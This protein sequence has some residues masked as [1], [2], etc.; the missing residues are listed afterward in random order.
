MPAI[1]HLSTQIIKRS[2]GRSSVACAAY[3]SGEALHDELEGTTFKFQREDRVVSSE[4]IAPAYATEDWATD[5]AKLWNSVEAVEKRCNAQ[6]AKE[7]EVA[8][9]NDLT[10][11]RQQELLAGW[12]DENFTQKGFIADV[13]IHRSPFGADFDNDHAHVMSTLREVDPETGGWKKLKTQSFKT[14][15]IDLEELRASWAKHVNAALQK[16]GL[17][18]QEVDHRSHKRRGITDVQPGIHVGYAGKGIE[19]RGGRSWRAEINREIH[20]QNRQILDE[21]KARVTQAANAAKRAAAAIADGFQQLGRGPS[22]TAP[23]AKPKPAPAPTWQPPPMR[24]PDKLEDE[25]PP[26][27]ADVEAE[28]RKKAAHEAAWR[29]QGGGGGVGG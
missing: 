22:E 14:A 8:L 26:V 3:R 1:F 5:R 27:A 19:D 20:R 18:D 2:E 9:P 16:A 7:T 10:L 25:P 21:I 11:K 6:L 4:I 17:E 29:Q 13:C 15:A 23:K 12:I 24:K 28:K